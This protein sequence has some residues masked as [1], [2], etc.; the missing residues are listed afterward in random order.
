[1]EEKEKKAPVNKKV[2]FLD[3][4]TGE[5]II[6]SES[7][8]CVLKYDIQTNTILE[9]CYTVK[10]DR[11]VPAQLHDGSIIVIIS[12]EVALELGFIYQTNS[13]RVLHPSIVNF[14]AKVNNAF[15]NFNYSFP[16]DPSLPNSMTLQYGTKSL[17]YRITEGL[18]YTFGIELET[19]SGFIPNFLAYKYNMKCLRDGSITGGE[20]VT[21]VLKGDSGIL[22]LSQITKLLNKHCKVDHKC[23]I[24]VHIGGINNNKM[25]N[26]AAYKLGL[27]LQDEIFSMLPRSR[28]FTRNSYYYNN[29]RNSAC[30]KLKSLNKLSIPFNKTDLLLD[31]YI[32][33]AYNEMYNWLS[34][35]RANKPSNKVNK[36]CKHPSGKYPNSRYVWLNFVPLN[37]VKGE[38]H[39]SSTSNTKVIWDKVKS[40]QTIEFRNHSASLN[41][42]KI[43]NWLLICMAFVNYVENRAVDILNVE[44]LSLREVLEFSYCNNL[45]YLLDY[46]DKRKNKFMVENPDENSKIE[47]LDYE[48]EF[49]NPEQL[50]KS[51]L[52]LIKYK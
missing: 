28:L 23:G 40:K 37:F 4:Y 2:L 36:L 29:G 45:E 13:D 48:E 22:Q 16:Y 12:I 44:S 27:L 17:S 51:K 20:Y 46:I 18:Q 24:H 30:D 26:V 14:D 11:T 6:P 33:D 32:D 31:V 41:F 34:D 7:Q 25:F 38:Y 3:Y 19:S 47:D 9:K 21:G 39:V 50:P 52:Q 35:S 42:V 15:N 5:P 10:R 1:M 49:I 8:E 43:R